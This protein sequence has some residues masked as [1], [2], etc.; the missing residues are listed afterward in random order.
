V[1][2]VFPWVKEI[3]LEELHKEIGAWRA[4]EKACEKL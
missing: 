1:R 4:K 3:I 2:E